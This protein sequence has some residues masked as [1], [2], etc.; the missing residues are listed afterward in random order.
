MTHIER[1]CTK[2]LT[3]KTHQTSI[4]PSSGANIYA[5]RE[6]VATHCH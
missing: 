4:K 6:M 5:D 3:S 2:L 1:L